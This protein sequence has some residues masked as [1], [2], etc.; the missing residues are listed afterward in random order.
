[1]N[2]LLLTLVGS[3]LPKGAVRDETTFLVLVSALGILIAIAMILRKFR[4]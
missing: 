3:I 2:G 4:K 1:V